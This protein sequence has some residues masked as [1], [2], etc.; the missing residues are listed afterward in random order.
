M[1]RKEKI[2]A[3][4]SS[5]EY[6]SLTFDELKIVLDVPESD[7]PELENILSEL[8]S[9]GRIFLSKK[10][11]YAAAAK[12]KL[13][14]GTMRSGI[15]AEFAF[16]LCD[17]GDDIHIEKSA[18]NTA[19]DGDRVLVRLISGKH[20][21][22]EGIVTKVLERTNTTLSA[23]MTGD[24]SA[25]PDNRR[26]SNKIK[27]TDVMTAECGDRVL[28]EITDYAPSGKLFGRVVSV[29][30]NSRDIKT[31][32]DAI[33]FEN[34]IKTE[35]SDEA[36]SEAQAVP[37]EIH[38]ADFPDRE[39]FTNELVFTIDG[40]DARDFDDAVSLKRLNNGNYEL[41]V[42]IADVTHY[43]TPNSCLNAE[44]LERGTSVYLPD[45]VIPMLPVEL[46]NGICS[47][48]PNV[49]RL[50]LSVI[51]EINSEGA[52]INHRIVN[53][54]IRSAYRMTYTNAAKILDND[55]EMCKK[56]SALTNVLFEMHQLSEIL[57]AKREKRG[58]INFDFPES[59][60]IL[61]KNGNPERIEKEIRNEAHK[62]IEEFMLVT[63]ETVAEFA[64]WA[65]LPFIYRVHEE[66]AQ[67]KMN[68]LR[69]FIGYF[70]LYIKGKEI[71]P[72]DL[73]QLLSSVS[74]TENETLIA[75][76]MLRSLMKADYRPECVGH[77]GLAAKFYCHFTSPI[78]RYPDLMIHRILKDYISGSD[79]SGYKAE[80]SEISKHSSEQERNAEL[81][82]RSTDDLYKAAYIS[83]FVGAEFPAKVS[84][85]TGFGMFA[86]L[87]NSVEGMIR[88]ETMHDDYYEFDEKQNALIGKRHGKIYR[89]G[90]S[91]EIEVIGADLL[92]RRIDFVLKSKNNSVHNK[93]S[94]IHNKKTAV[95]N[96]KIALRNN[97]KKQK[98]GKRNG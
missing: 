47:L 50:T 79:T 84:G 39:D 49:N 70:G 29:L 26:I 9:E 40:D 43:V 38:I 74:G 5:P 8:I 21:R 91:I 96:K 30:G 83:S 77:F 36:L 17:D 82:E 75:T 89:I 53:G 31:L 13:F 18:F 90:D 20:S 95:Q 81:T 41:G 64:Y 1:N 24:F 97:R 80:I 32:T 51:M 4:I 62:L 93:K 87:E 37:A 11:R 7:L 63:N 10:G 88:L 71:F 46:S 25:R 55:P 56:Y 44:A 34:H 15:G 33:L 28:I 19:I 65:D 78:R 12:N 16:V 3:Y 85:I 57:Q 94:A 73:Q 67:D 27:L 42:H 59:R 6:T 58:S 2:Y 98:R 92:T 72:R 68:A 45:R 54:I 60:I 76:Y 14:S 48:N 69:N 86:E 52:V 61:D 23:V 66:P 35:F 22:R